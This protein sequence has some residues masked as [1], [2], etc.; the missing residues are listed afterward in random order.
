MT[1]LLV[2]GAP[3]SGKTTLAS[4]LAAQLGWPQVHRDELYAGISAAGDVDREQVV[5]RGVAA[6]W[7][8]T[9]AYA[10]AGS[11]VIAEATLYRGQSE[12]EVRDVLGGPWPVRNVHCTTPR[13][14]E[15]FVARGHE[16]RLNDRALANA[17]ATVPAL[18]LDCPLLEVDTT[19][20]YQPGL[21]A[22]VRW[23]TVPSG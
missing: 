15:R 21:D 10:R 8:V 5:P 11:S 2:S 20:G 23:A 22:L 6:F 7:S 18:D 9:A 14:H 17:P 13:W 16:A 12:A 19:N 4:A 1:I 3:G